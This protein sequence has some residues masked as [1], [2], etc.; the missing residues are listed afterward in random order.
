MSN[1]SKRDSALVQSVLALDNYLSEL[2]RVGT[3][4]NSTDLTSDIDLEHIQ[5]L[6][7]RFAE[8]AQGVSQ[9]LVNLS[10]QLEEARARAEAMSERVSRQAELW[11]IRKKEQNEKLEKFRVLGERVRKVNAA[12]TSF[13]GEQGH[14]LTDEDREKL[15]SNIPALEAE[16]DLLI[17]GLQ[18]FRKSARDSRMRTLEK[19]AA[20]LEQSLQAVRNKLR[21]LSPT[22]D[23]SS[24]P[25]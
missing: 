5:K 8:C 4:I 13:R 1:K 6:L 18:D 15:R 23:G 3:K 9:E 22:T 12:M 17:N 20:S 19:N 14:G 7:N 25:N 16:L 21:S 24:D 11:N 10:T 2:E